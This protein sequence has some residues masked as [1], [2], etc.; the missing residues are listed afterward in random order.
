MPDGAETIVLRRDR[1]LGLC[2]RCHTVVRTFDQIGKKCGRSFAAGVI[3][4]GSFEV[5]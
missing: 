4:R 5:R 2:P 1:P 3:G